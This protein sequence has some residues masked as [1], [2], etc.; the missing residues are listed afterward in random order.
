[1]LEYSI[2]AISIAAKTNFNN[3]KAPTRQE[4]VMKKLLLSVCAVVCLSGVL[5]AADQAKQKM[6]QDKMQYEKME[7]MEKMQCMGDKMGMGHMM[8]PMMGMMMNKSMVP[9]KDGFVVMAGSKLMKYD[10]NL[11]LVKEVE[12]KMDM[13]EMQ[14]K[15]KEMMENCPM[16]KKESM[17]EEKNETK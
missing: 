4:V 12:I 13:K 5:M 11:N 9:V 14:K 3:T 1:L 15:M 8:C 16:M 2:K 6:E 7:K 17:E 10:N